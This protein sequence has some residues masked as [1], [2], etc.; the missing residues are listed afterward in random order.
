VR[1]RNLLYGH[2]ARPVFKAVHPEEEKER[3]HETT[4]NRGD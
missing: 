1:R 2:A 3:G 4:D